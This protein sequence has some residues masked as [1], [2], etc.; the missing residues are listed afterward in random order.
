MLVKYIHYCNELFCHWLLQWFSLMEYSCSLIQSVG[1]QYKE[2]RG[3]QIVSV[4]RRVT[5]VEVCAA[6][7]V[8][9]FMRG[10]GQMTFIVTNP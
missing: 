10:M 6:A 4:L 9:I 5:A 7:V 8:D 2:P 1:L 3:L